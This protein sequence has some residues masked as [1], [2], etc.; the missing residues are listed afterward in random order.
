MNTTV[1]KLFRGAWMV[2][3]GIYVTTRSRAEKKEIRTN[4]TKRTLNRAFALQQLSHLHIQ[5][6][7]RNRYIEGRLRFHTTPAEELWNN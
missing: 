3:T 4:I 7:A 2:A 5:E 1:M 6:L